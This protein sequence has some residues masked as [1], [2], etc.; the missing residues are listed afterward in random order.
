MTDVGIGRVVD[1]K[2]EIIALIGK[3]GMSNVWLAKDRRLEKL[4]A[5]KEIKPNVVGVQGEANRKAIIDEANFMKRLDYPA[6]PRVV[7]I[8]DMGATIFVIMDFVP[9]TAL[10]KLFKRQNRQ[11]FDQYEVIDWG[12]QLCNVLE[13]LHEMTPPIMYRDMK[14]ANIMLNDDGTVKLI[15]FGIAMEYWPSRGQDLNIQGTFGYAPPEQLDPTVQ[16]D[17]RADIYSL[18]VTIYALVTGHTPKLVRDEHGRRVNDDYGRPLI[19][20]SMRPIREVNPQLSEGLEHIILRAT[21]LNPDERYQTI[22]EM[23]YDLEHYEQLTEEYRSVQLAKVDSFRRWVIAAI[24]CVVAGAICLVISNALRR[25]DISS[26]LIDAQTKSVE[27]VAGEASEAEESYAAAIELDPSNIEVY[28][29]LLDN[30]YKDDY[31][32]TPTEAGRW[33]RIFKENQGSMEGEKGFAK[34]CY[35]AGIT[36]LCYYQGEQGDSATGSAVVNTTRAAE[37]FEL[38]RLAADAD[39]DGVP[40]NL[41]EAEFAATNTYGTIAQFYDEIQRKTREGAAT[42]DTYAT[43][44]EALRNAVAS[45]PSDAEPAVRLRLY[46]VAFE[47]ISSPTYMAGFARA[48][49]PQNQAEA[50]LQTVCTQARSLQLEAQSNP[51]TLLPI[52]EEVVDGQENAMRNIETTYANPTLAASTAAANGEGEGE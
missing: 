34:L 20:F 35:D 21:Q 24:A 43:Y 37:W 15:D 4:W 3:G 44:W 41:S 39:D 16:T 8:I 14:P 11:P 27:E 45:L 51:D 38:A 42:I 6:I 47:S 1:N 26:Y 50:F 32:L 28:G 36:F 25:S 9:G 7:D 13:Y 18:G 40:E 12:V 49:I 2:Y 17:I 10:D 33:S 5:V 52:Y 23:R 29:L 19:D 22:E 46:R 30:V 48:S 31:V